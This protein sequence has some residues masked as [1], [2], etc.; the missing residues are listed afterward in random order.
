MPNLKD[1]LKNFLPQSQQKSDS[2]NQFLEA[3]GELLDNFKT[4]IDDFQTYNDFEKVKE[5]QLDN[6]AKQFDIVYPRNMSDERRRN[7]LRDVVTL[8]RS[9]GTT[10]SMKRVF[11]LIGWEVQIKEYWVVNPDWYTNPT[12]IYTITN[13][14]G[15]TFDL[16]LY[17]TINGDDEYYRNDKIYIDLVDASGNIYPQRQ[18]YG[19]PYQAIDDVNFVKVPYL[20]IIVTSEDFDLFTQPYTDNGNSYTYDT[21]EEF[22]ILT[23]IRNYF[24]DVIRPANVAI[25]EI[26]TPFALSDTFVFFVNSDS[27][28]ALITGTPNISFNNANPYTITRDAGSFLTDGFLE[29]SYINVT[30]SVSNN[31]R[32]KIRLVT[33]TTLT[34]YY[35]TPLVSELTVAG[36]SIIDEGQTISTQ[37]TGAEY[38]GTLSYGG[39]NIDRY[40]LGETMGNF[41]YGTTQMDYYGI[42]EDA[43]DEIIVTNYAIGAA[44]NQ[45]RRLLRKNSDI[46][47]TVP[48]DATITVYAS[49]DSHEVI[50]SGS[51]TWV[52]IDT[53]ITNVTNSVYTL[54]NYF[55]VFVKIDTASA[56]GTIDTTV[57]LY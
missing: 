8:Y 42:E 14:S 43:P 34:L 54:T 47:V 18:I 44:G 55:S 15:A 16:G 41:Q 11:K 39:H 7:Y 49:K 38:D 31:K 1:N 25:L 36:V 3:V 53:G 6:L 45:N 30:G 28:G 29:E 20:K 13:E 24:L 26:S 57:N 4:A 46:D 27:G 37:N 48:S 23:Y 17:D 21:T 19:E 52:I 9:K 56:T 35:E 33:A 2:L 40:V 5:S 10:K 51:P 32:F 50:V 12:D 22:E